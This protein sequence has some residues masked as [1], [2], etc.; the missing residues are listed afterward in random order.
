[1]I[2][3]C[4]KEVESDMYQWAS[5]WEDKHNNKDHGL[6]NLEEFELDEPC[7]AKPGQTCPGCGKLWSEVESVD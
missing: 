5:D 3:L 6:G 4:W 1:M 7:I 2:E